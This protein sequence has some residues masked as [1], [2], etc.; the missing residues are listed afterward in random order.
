LERFSGGGTTAMSGGVFYAGGTQF[1]RDAG[2]NDTAQ[3]MYDYLKQEGKDAISEQTLWRFCEQRPETVTA[4]T[5][6]AVRPSALSPMVT[7]AAFL[8]RI[9][10]SPVAALVVPQPSLPTDVQ[11]CR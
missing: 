1:L 6:L 3:D 11:S 10:C 7:S 2:V 9:A 5:P 8:W 4:Y